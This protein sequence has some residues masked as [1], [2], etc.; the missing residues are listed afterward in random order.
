MSSVKK[1]SQ[2]R[3]FFVFVNF[4]ASL[5]RNLGSVKKG[6]FEYGKIQSKDEKNSQGA[7]NE[8]LKVKKRLPKDENI[9]SKAG[10]SMHIL[11]FN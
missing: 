9:D 2:K 7:K 3:V 11:I 4:V 1:Y 10:K 8:D 5:L 6:A